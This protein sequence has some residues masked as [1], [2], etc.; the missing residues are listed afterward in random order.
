MKKMK[1]IAVLLVTAVLAL[2][3]VTNAQNSVP[4]KV[5]AGK[6]DEEMNAG[7]K[8][9]I[10]AKVISNFD[11]MFADASN[12]IWSKEKNLNRVYFESKG[13]VTRATFN[14]KGQ[15]LYSISTYSEQLLPKDVLL[16][17]KETYYGKSI[18]G[19]TEVKALDKTAYIV[20]L[21]D[22]TSWLHIKVLD[23]EMTEEKV[24]LKA[25]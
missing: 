18:F 10:N 17:V 5:N 2:G 20:I 6:F 7:G 14:Q 19:V 25:Q 21:E 12:V 11:R 24:Y 4:F 16:M 23:G 22:K 9:S 1:K 15:F 3:I 8:T 13:K